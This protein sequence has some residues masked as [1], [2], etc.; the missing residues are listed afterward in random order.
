MASS[1][2]GG[3]NLSIEP[4]WSGATAIDKPQMA[5]LEDYPSGAW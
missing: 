1:L 4:G 5:V 3:Y 2:P